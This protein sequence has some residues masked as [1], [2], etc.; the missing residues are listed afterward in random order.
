MELRGF[1]DSPEKEPCGQNASKVVGMDNKSEKKQ[2]DAVD[3]EGAK[4]PGANNVE[5]NASGN[6]YLGEILHLE[7]IPGT[8]SLDFIFVPINLA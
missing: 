4:Q 1:D 3:K 7:S 6:D 8:L 5:D 2:A